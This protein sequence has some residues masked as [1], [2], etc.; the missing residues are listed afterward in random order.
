MQPDLYA[1]LGVDKSATDE[2]LK[3]A[4]RRKAL[5]Y[6]PDRNPDDP[7]ALQ[8]FK[9]VAYAWSVLSDPVKRLQYDRFG[10]VFSD[11]RSQGPFG[12]SD[13]IDLGEVVGSLFKDLFGRKKK[14]KKAG[15]DPRDLRY[16]V[17]I[18][19]EECARGVTKDVQF[20]RATGEK[21]KVEEKLKVKVPPGV[22]TGQKLKVA[23]KGYGG[24]KGTG[25]LYVVVN[26]ADHTF[27]K[28]RGA[29]V[30]CDVPVSYAQALLGAELEV[31]TLK[32]PAVVRLPPG[33]QPGTVL[34]LKQRGLPRV[35]GGKRGDLYV[36]VV[37][38]L[39][40]EVSADQRERL[41]ALDREMLSTPSPMREQ[42]LKM[43]RGEDEE[44][45][46]S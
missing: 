1:L 23:G 36:K 44:E 17:T 6:H 7:N 39:P 37:L 46:A 14:K 20:L 26:V 32:D 41:L 22:D 10:R 19:L 27:F 2:E 34:T 5:E 28:R 13:E 4:Y 8:R 33:T 29:D 3:K 43:L 18:T 16:T 30:F 9:E 12:A 15:P 40:P 31:P 45:R 35:K 24:S 42:L 21:V 11:G 38:D 25:D